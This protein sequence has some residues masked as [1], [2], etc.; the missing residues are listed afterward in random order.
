MRINLDSIIKN[1][2]PKLHKRMPGFV[3]NIIK[4]IIK[5]DKFNHILQSCDGLKNIEFLRGALDIMKIE[6]NAIGTHNIDPTKSYVFASNHP[7]GGLDG[8]VLLEIINKYNGAVIVVNDL[9]MNVEPL[10]DMFIPINKHGGQNS[11][12]SRSMKKAFDSNMQVVF[13]PA[14]LCSRR[15]KGK[16]TDLKWKKTFLAK[17]IEHKRDIIPVYVNNVN[18]RLFYTVSSIRK[19]LGLKMNLEMILL[20]SEMF[21]DKPTRINVTFGEPISY[22]TFQRDCNYNQELKIIRKKCYELENK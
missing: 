21:R 18:S 14:G 16:I 15:I 2:S 10:K 19:W 11:D 7:L 5:V 4:K 20:P 1:K 12:T 22:K 8:L 9:L 17:A 3:I 6:R 13:F